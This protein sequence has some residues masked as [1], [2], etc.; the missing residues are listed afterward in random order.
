MNTY[1][2]LK[3]RAGTVKKSIAPNIEVTEVN[4]RKISVDTFKLNDNKLIL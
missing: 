1:S 3:Y 2:T 4:F